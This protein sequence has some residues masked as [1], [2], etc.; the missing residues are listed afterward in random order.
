MILN[1]GMAQSGGTLPV[2]IFEL[3]KKFTKEY[4][5]GKVAR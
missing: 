1:P 5:D 3:A 2:E 4:E